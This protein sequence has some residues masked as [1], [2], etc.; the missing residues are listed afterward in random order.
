[1]RKARH[2]A[3]ITFS[4]HFEPDDLTRRL[5]IRPTKITCM[6][7]KKPRGPDRYLWSTWTLRSS[8]SEEEGDLPMHLYDLIEILSPVWPEVIRISRESEVTITGWVHMYEDGFTPTMV[9]PPEVVYRA[10]QL[11]ASCDIDLYLLPADDEV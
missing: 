8:L 11:H 6:G 5:R 4:G 2:K 7:G 1:M 9:F 10:A 3:E